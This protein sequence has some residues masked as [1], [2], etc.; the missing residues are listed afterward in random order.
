MGRQHDV[1]RHHAPEAQS[2]IQTKGHRHRPLSETERARNR[3]KSQVRAKVE[4]VFLVM[5][6]IFG[7]VKVRDRGLAKNT[8][9]L[10]VTCGLTNL[11]MARHRLLAGA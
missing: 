11:Y 6:Q 8:N 7:W 3:T 4:H 5:K 10:L 1:I 9:W 2:F